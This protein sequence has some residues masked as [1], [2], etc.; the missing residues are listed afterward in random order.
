M[1]NPAKPV[2]AALYCRMSVA[3]LGDN[4]K[5]ERQEEDCRAVCERKGWIPLEAFIDN[6]K[7]AWRRDRKRPAWDR[8]LEGVSAGQFDAI[9]VYHGDRLIRQ[10]YDLE[11]LLGLA[12]DR[13]LLLA[14]P[15][16]TRN[17]DSADDRFILRIEAANACR[18]SDNTSRRVRRAKQARRDQGIASLGRTRAYGRTEDGG[19]VEEE[20]ARIRDAFARIMAGETKT[21]V[22]RS[23]VIAR[24]PT[25]KGGQWRYGSFCQMLARPDLAGFVGHQGRVVRVATNLEPIVD[26]AVWRTVAEHA[27][28]SAAQLGGKPRPRKHLLSGIAVCSGC[29][30]PVGSNWTATGTMRYR[31]LWPSCPA[32]TSR[33]MLRL[34]EFMIGAVLARLADPRL[35]RAVAKL[36][37]AAAAGDASAAGELAALEERRAATVRQFAGSVRMSPAELDGLLAGFDAQIAAA[38]ARLASDQTVVVLRGLRNLDRPGWDALSLDRRRSVIRKLLTV[39][40]LP[41]RRGPGFDPGSVRVG[42]VRWGSA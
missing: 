18:E 26:P 33:N 8:M 19:I 35:W 40:L 37:A 36:E 39:E 15:T 3:E 28:A 16:G 9:V 34:D 4:E 11:M 2:R 31:C 20:A 13:G 41:A 23:W 5:V 32:P 10:P 27:A 30:E 21:G 17:L 42:R 24:V 12:R 22:W 6:N 7:S 25:V 29:T 1:L 14:S 38:R